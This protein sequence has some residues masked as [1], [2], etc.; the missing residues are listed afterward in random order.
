M[1][2][3]HVKLRSTFASP[4]AK[5]RK[6]L[7]LTP[8]HIANIPKSK[9]MENLRATTA[10][11]GTMRQQAIKVNFAGIRSAVKNTIQRQ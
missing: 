8:N 3:N 1:L 5:S 10:L 11:N 9:I 2:R 7:N 6:L 4:E